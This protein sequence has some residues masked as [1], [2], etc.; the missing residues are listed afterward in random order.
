M[1]KTDGYQTCASKIILAKIKFCL[2]KSIWGSDISGRQTSDGSGQ[3]YQL[4]N[5][6]GNG[7][8]NLSF[9]QVDGIGGGQ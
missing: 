1:K 7:I 8:L 3:Q 5:T 2:E 4:I 9:S 6:C